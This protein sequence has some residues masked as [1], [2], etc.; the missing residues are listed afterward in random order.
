VAA[1]TA[2]GGGGEGGSGGGAAKTPLVSGRRTVYAPRC[3]VQY[4][5]VNFRVWGR[6]FRI[7]WSSAWI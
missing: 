1:A 3:K 4:S 7:C 6:G 5:V 2:G